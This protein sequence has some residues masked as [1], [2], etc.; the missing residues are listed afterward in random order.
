MAKLMGK[1]VIVIG[2]RS[3]IGLGVAIA[4][5]QRGAELVTA[6]G[7][8]PVRG[9]CDRRPLRGQVPSGG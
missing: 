7:K 9:S 2:G 5:L 4:A 8:T 3:G 1:K 6:M